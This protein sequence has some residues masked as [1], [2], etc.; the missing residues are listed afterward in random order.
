MRNQVAG[1]KR[2][3]RANRAL[4]DA[5]LNATHGGGGGASVVE[6]DDLDAA[7]KKRLRMRKSSVS[8]PVQWIS[9]QSHNPFS[10]LPQLPF[11]QQQQPTPIFPGQLDVPAMSGVA[12]EDCE[13][14]Q[15]PGAPVATKTSAPASTSH[16]SQSAPELIL[17]SSRRARASALGIDLEIDRKLGVSMDRLYSCMLEQEQE[18]LQAAAESQGRQTVNYR[19]VRALRIKYCA[20][21]VN[22]LGLSRASLHLAVC[23][24]A[25]SRVWESAGCVVW[26]SSANAFHCRSLT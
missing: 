20:H 2:T 1:R 5:F 3:H 10:Q 15:L 17:P 14:K 25:L 6:T 18:Q 13:D 22:L 19:K 7:F 9:S 16:L 26:K 12:P 24:L 11:T 8:V 23:E 4:A 21:M